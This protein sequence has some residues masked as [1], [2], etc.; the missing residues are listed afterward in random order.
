M[1][2]VYARMG[3]TTATVL[4]FLLLLAGSSASAFA[5]DLPGAPEIDASSMANALMVLGGGLLIIRGRL[6]R[7]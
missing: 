1:K 6:S 7:K 4:G 3:R 5:V 2:A